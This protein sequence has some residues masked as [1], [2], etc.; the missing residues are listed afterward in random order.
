MAA[1]ACSRSAADEAVFWRERA[2]LLEGLNTRLAG[3][4]V[5]LEAENATLAGTVAAQQEQLAALK[6][7]VVTLSRMLFGTSSEKDG[8]GKKRAGAEAAGAGGDEGRGPGGGAAGGRRRGQRPGSAGH[9][10]RRREHL[11]AEEQ[12]HDVPAGARCCPRC[13]RA[14][15]LLGEDVSEQVSWRVRVWRVVHRR[16]K[17]ARCCRCPVP[18]V[19]T[20]PGPP[21]L[22]ARGLFTTEFCVNLLIAKYALGL[23]FNR[24]IAMLSFQ[25]LEVAPGTLAGVARRLD[26]LLAP[27]AGAIAV[28]NAAAGHA[29][30]DETSWRVFGQPA[31]NGGSRWWLWVFTAPDTVVY[32]IA[33]SRSLKVLQDHYGARAGQLPEGRG[34]LVISSDFYS[35]YRSFAEI[36]GVTPLWCWSHVRRYFIRAGDAHRKELGSWASAWVARIGVLYAAHR[37]LAAAPAGTS[38]HARAAAAFEAALAEIDAHRRIQGA[39]PDL[40]H[41]AAAKVLA[42]LNREW[43]GLAAHRD[44]PDLPLDNNTAERAIRTPVV[45]RKNYNGSGSRW[46]ADLAGHAWTILGTARIAGHNPR[47]YL[48]TYLQACAADGGRPPAGQALAAL[49][50]WTITLPGPPGTAPGR[51]P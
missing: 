27:L 36:D 21:A 20:A 28:R 41:P 47:A 18:A 7:R 38:E 33:P 5:R 32:A 39:R 10:R 9:G 17:Y 11:E 15:E 13:G 6:Q 46:A 50:P 49:L 40:L 51:P 30:A 31:D 34:P 8:A 22:I 45:G 19:L 4:N 14:Y 2:E 1:L 44:F 16:R 43:D 12:I 35:V 24:V 48:D 3:E 42:T 25:G 26:G 23:P 29:H 37:Q